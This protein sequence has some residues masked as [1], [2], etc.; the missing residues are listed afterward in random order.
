MSDEEQ[1]FD[2]IEEVL[3]QHQNFIGETEQAS[4]ADIACYD[5][6]AQLEPVNLID[7]RNRKNITG[8]D[9]Y[10]NSLIMT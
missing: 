4:I 6:I 1:L 5:E 3:L 9:V 2:Y 10:G 8:W 7:F